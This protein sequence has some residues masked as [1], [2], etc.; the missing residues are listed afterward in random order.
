MKLSR[1]NGMEKYVR[2]PGQM[3]QVKLYKRREKKKS[4][5]MKNN[6]WVNDA[7]KEFSGMKPK[8][9]FQPGAFGWVDRVTGNQQG[10]PDV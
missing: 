10:W 7:L 6:F 1:F 4:W 5:R 3:G 9:K 8:K 2:W